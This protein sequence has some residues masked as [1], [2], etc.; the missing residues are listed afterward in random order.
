MDRTI[1]MGLEMSHLIINLTA[2]EL[3]NVI[4]IL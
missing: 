4:V 3:D 2:V 1:V